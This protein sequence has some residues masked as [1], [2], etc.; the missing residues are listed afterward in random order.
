MPPLLIGLALGAA[1]AF[2]LDPQQGA[3]RRTVARDKLAHGVNQGRQFALAAR[4]DLR[5]RADGMAAEVRSIVRRE[6]VNP[7][8]LMARV[9][10]RMGRCVSHPGAVQVMAS[11]AG[12]VSLSGDILAAEHAKLLATARSV[13]GVRGLEDRLIVHQDAGRLPALQG[14][15]TAS[16]S[17]MELM[18]S[19]WTPGIRLLSGGAGTALVAAALARG[20]VGGIFALAAGALLLARTGLNRPLPEAMR[21][22]CARSEDTRRTEVRAEAELA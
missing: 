19:R 8:R 5:Q 12:I 20:G 21:E 4:K 17:H 13:R 1:G 10:A 15:E 2:I 11:H 22:Q 14:G 7:D 16:G 18:Q 6:D 3:R 9:R